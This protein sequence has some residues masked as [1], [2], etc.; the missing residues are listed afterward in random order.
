MHR[1]VLGLTK[2]FFMVT[3]LYTMFV[4]SLYAL[5]ATN[6]SQKLECLSAETGMEPACRNRAPFESIGVW[7]PL[8]VGRER[9]QLDCLC[10]HRSTSIRRTGRPTSYDASR[11]PWSNAFRCLRIPDLS[12]ICA[13][14]TPTPPLKPQFTPQQR[15]RQAPSER[16]PSRNLRSEKVSLLQSDGKRGDPRSESTRCC[17]TAAATAL[18]PPLLLPGRA[19]AL[20][21]H[22]P[23]EENVLRTPNPVDSGC[24][25]GE[26]IAT[27]F[28]IIV[29]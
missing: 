18:R 21:A 2:A 12:L 1:P 9:V 11:A 23:I 5:Y 4:L 13:I 14:S 15:L 27:S 19:V 24:E 28:R 7:S 20:Q 22:Q 8:R 10:V 25:N 16:V 29:S 6:S 17:Q 3:P 26:R